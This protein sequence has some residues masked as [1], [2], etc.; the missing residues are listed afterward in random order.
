MYDSNFNCLGVMDFDVYA[1]VGDLL[2]DTGGDLVA[3]VLY[4][5][6]YPLI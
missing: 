1:L 5:V 3:V 2:K 4:L 6:T